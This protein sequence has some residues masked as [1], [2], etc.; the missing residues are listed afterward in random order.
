M[1]K[2]P[3]I[4]AD[5]HALIVITNIINMWGKDDKI[6]T[7]ANGIITSKNADGT[8]AI[9]ER[10]YISEINTVYKW[11]DD[12]V[13]HTEDPYKKDVFEY[14]LKTLELKAADC[15][16][17]VILIG[18]LLQAIGYPIVVAMTSQDIIK[19][20]SHVFLLVGCP[21]HN[22]PKKISGWIPIDAITNKPIT[23]IPPYAWG[24]WRKV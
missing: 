9:K 17:Y 4:D 20:L 15:D 3:L 6:R 24:I 14:P 11:V 13:R 21:P 10:D 8:W 16:G 2:V 12:N 23:W 7:I 5:I 18:S 22:P 19:T 1:R